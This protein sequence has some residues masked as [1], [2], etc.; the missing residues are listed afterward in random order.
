MKGAV[1]G[2]KEIVVAL[3][4][5]EA[6]PTCKSLNKEEKYHIDIVTLVKDAKKMYIEKET[7]PNQ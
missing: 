7:K 3:L 5:S 4:K 2:N 1:N 6:N